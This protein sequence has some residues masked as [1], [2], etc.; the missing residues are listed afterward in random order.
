MLSSQKRTGL[1]RND[2]SYQFDIWTDES[3]G[4]CYW[5][6][7][8]IAAIKCA[9]NS[10]FTFFVLVVV[11]MQTHSAYHLVFLVCSNFLCCGIVCMFGC[12][13]QARFADCQCFYYFYTTILSKNTPFCCSTIFL[14]FSLLYVHMSK[15]INVISESCLCA[16]CLLAWQ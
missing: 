2:S 8:P 5:S 16:A 11:V 4:I 1:N 14:F 13:L 9:V 15:H 12:F 3:C 7:V 6:N 10:Q